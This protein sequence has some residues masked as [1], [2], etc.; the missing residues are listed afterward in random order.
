VNLRYA[1]G[2]NEHIGLKTDL[3]HANQV[4]IARAAREQLAHG[5]HCTTRVVRWQR[6]AGAIGNA[7][8]Q[9]I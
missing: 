3:R 6:N 2:A 9:F 8:D 5:G 7:C 1:T 4:Q